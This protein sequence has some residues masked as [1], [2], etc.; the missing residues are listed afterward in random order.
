MTSS[1]DGLDNEL[2]NLKEAEAEN[3]LL[4]NVIRRRKLL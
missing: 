3:E 4:K 2:L 1:F